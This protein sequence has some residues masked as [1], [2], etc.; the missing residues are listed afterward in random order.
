MDTITQNDACL[1]FHAEKN[2]KCY[3]SFRIENPP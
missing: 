2:A 1:A 3:A